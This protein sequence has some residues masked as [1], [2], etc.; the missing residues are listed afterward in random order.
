MR[1][2]SVA[3]AIAEILALCGGSANAEPLAPT[4]PWKVAY[5][6]AQCVASRE[7]GTDERPVTLAL[8]PSP[9]GGVMR[10]LVLRNGKVD[11]HEESATLKFGEESQHI[12]LLDYADDQTRLRIT[13]VNVPMSDFKKNLGAS[14]I[15][16]ES[17]S[18]AHA[19]FAVSQLAEV[20]T[21]LD[22]CLLDLQD[23]WNVGAKYKSR[24]AT[25]STPEHPLY[26]LFKG[27]D[28][29]QVSLN[30]NE[31]GS[32]SITFLV[33]ETGQI[34]DCSVDTTSGVAA[35]DTMTCYIVSKRAHIGPA[36]D[37]QGR[38]IRSAY[39]E[40]INWRIVN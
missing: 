8:K 30:R 29:P 10:I 35:L 27:G 26:G 1:T 2:I 4:S 20:T 23:Y 28:Y 16:I 36:H 7:Y 3:I 21:E 34:R 6:A 31:Q 12:N 39:T 17:V 18:T 40:T 11:A 9:N 5:D 24:I 15:G 14:S 37:S 38:A 25:P 22:K 13:A 19:S 33:D 32:V